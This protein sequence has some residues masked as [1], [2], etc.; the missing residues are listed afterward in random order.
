LRDRKKDA[1]L[2]VGALLLVYVYLLAVL[3]VLTECLEVAHAS[4]KGV[5]HLE[6]LLVLYSE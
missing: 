6:A 5:V 4:S 1:S 2:L 3:S